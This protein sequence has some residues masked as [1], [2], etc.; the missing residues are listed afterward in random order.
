[1]PKRGRS[2]G[3]ATVTPAA[4]L[5]LVPVLLR[6]WGKR[7]ATVRI[8]FLSNT[9][10][11]RLKWL[12]LRR[13]AAFVNVLAFP[14][15]DGFPHP[16]SS[17]RSLGDVYLNEAYRTDPAEGLRMFIHGFAHVC[18]FNHVGRRDTIEMQAAEKRALARV[19]AMRGWSSLFHEAVHE[20]THRT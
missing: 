18:G 5:S 11:Q 12:H 13:R 2:G 8:A 19:V 9:E 17:R 10:L 16:E 4:L 15:P 7:P 1:M 14:E 3:G 20:D 6:L